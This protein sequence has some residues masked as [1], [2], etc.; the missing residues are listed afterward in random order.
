MG[1]LRASGDLFLYRD[2]CKDPLP[3]DDQE[4]RVWGGSRVLRRGKGG[5][6]RDLSH[7]GPLRTQF[8]G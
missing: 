5:I 8:Y 6:C 2:S 1:I 3:P 4:F 7:K